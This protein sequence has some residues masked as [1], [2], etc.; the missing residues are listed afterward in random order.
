LEYRGGKIDRSLSAD[1]E[2]KSFCGIQGKKKE[3][4]KIR[5]WEVEKSGIKDSY[6]PSIPPLPTFQSFHHS[7][8]PFQFHPSTLPPSPH[9]PNI[10][11]FH[12]SLLIIHHSSFIIPISPLLRFSKPNIPISQHPMHP[13]IHA[14][15]RPCDYQ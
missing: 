13:C 6:H 14:V 5:S 8:I 4:E 11:I 1:F 10:P 15:M 7:I 12:I 3:D 2:I 9:Y